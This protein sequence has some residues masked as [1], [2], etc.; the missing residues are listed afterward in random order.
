MQSLPIKYKSQVIFNSDAIKT[1]TIKRT[2]YR[3]SRKTISCKITCKN[4]PFFFS[5]ARSQSSGNGENLILNTIITHE[6]TRQ[7]KACMNDRVRLESARRCPIPLEH[8]Y[9]YCRC[10]LPNESALLFSASANT[11]TRRGW[12]EHCEGC[13]LG[14]SCCT[15]A[16]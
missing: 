14:A 5:R 10:W 6:E 4:E 2:E 16:R 8:T 13:L 11:S 9:H 1:L 12:T 7:R 3:A 15:T